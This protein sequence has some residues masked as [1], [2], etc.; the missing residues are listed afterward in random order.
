MSIKISLLIR[1]LIMEFA[2]EHSKSI[3]FS[4]YLKY[5]RIDI[6]SLEGFDSNKP[7]NHWELQFFHYRTLVPKFTK[8][9]VWLHFRPSINHKTECAVIGWSICR[10]LRFSVV[11]DFQ[12]TV[13]QK[14]ARSSQFYCFP[15]GTLQIFWEGCNLK[16]SP[17]L[18]CHF[19]VTLKKRL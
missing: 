18:L 7:L 1:S 14:K 4:Q 5:V 9:W 6:W 19:W 12:Q 16:E 11:L 15:F 13:V 2:F 3:I 10:I 8:M 17:T